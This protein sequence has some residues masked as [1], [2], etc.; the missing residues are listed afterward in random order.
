MKM[1]ALQRRGS[2]AA[3]GVGGG[4]GVVASGRLVKRDNWRHRL[5]L[6][7]SRHLP[8]HQHENLQYVQQMPDLGCGMVARWVHRGEE[9]RGVDSVVSEPD[10]TSSRKGLEL[11]RDSRRLGQTQ[12]PTEKHAQTRSLDEKSFIFGLRKCIRR[13]KE[14]GRTRGGHKWRGAMEK[15][16]GVLQAPKRVQFASS[17]SASCAPGWESC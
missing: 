12:K 14:V 3:S 1:D 16:K 15:E 11:A 17:L 8:Q 9:G 10:Q 7:T 6:G 13:C 2:D 5:E 4:F